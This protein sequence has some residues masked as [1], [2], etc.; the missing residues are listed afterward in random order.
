[1]K[2]NTE[3][4]INSLFNLQT[5]TYDKSQELRLES[6][7]KRRLDFLLGA[8]YVYANT[9]TSSAALLA[10]GPSNQ[11]NG[12]P[13]ETKTTGVFGSVSYKLF[14][15]LTLSAEARYQIDAISLYN[16]GANNGPLTKSVGATFRNFL[17]RVIAKF[18]FSPNLNIY[19]SYS[20]GVNPGTFNA[21]F[22]TLSQAQRD[23]LAQ[24]YGAG[25]RPSGWPPPRSS[26][27]R[28]RVLP[29]DLVRP[30]RQ[31]VGRDNAGERRD[32]GH[33][34]HHQYRQD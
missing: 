30:D 21:N 13:V 5:H 32:H 8:S 16:R 31:P 26:R 15:P 11:L 20:K 6:S 4:Y 2:A 12:N 14:E 1:M 33:Q 23:L 27:D 17:P 29:R 3:A 24:Q 19:A 10:T 7:G 22:V 18:Q 9:A 28:G 25:A 34:R